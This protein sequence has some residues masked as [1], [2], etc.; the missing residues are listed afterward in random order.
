[1]RQRGCPLLAIERFLL[2]LNA[3]ATLPLHISSAPSLQKSF[4]LSLTLPS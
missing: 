1:M 4:L 3:S 2:L